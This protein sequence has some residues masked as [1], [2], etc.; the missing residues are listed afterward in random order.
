MKVTF[1]IVPALTDIAGQCRIVACNA[2]LKEIAGEARSVRDHYSKYPQQWKEA[3]VMNSHGQV[4]A[5]DAPPH[6]WA[7]LRADE[8]LMAG[9][10]YEVDVEAAVA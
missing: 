9:V 1:Y 8:P 4:V 6:V 5:L 3:G 10:T 2:S 7:E